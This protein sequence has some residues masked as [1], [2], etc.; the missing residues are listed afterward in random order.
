MHLALQAMVAWQHVKTAAQERWREEVGEGV[1]S[2]AIAVLVMAMIGFAMWT[3][4][5]RVF[6]D[7]GGKIETKVG[8]IGGGSGGA[9]AP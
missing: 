9:G 4:F 2:T 6:N 3:V 1:I 5:D 7:A 8:Q